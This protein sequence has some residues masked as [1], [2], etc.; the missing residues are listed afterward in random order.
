MEVCGCEISTVEG[1]LI[2]FSIYIPPAVS[3]NTSQ[4]K[5]LINISGNTPVLFCGDFNAH[6]EV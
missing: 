1:K 3:F 5:S 2:I 4:L 6:N